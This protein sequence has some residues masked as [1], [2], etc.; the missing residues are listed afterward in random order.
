VAIAKDGTVEVQLDSNP[1]TGYTWTLASGGKG[2]EQTS[3][4]YT[5]N[6]ES[7]MVGGGGKQTYTF[8]ATGEGENDLVFVYK[9]AWEKEEANRAQV[10]VDI[11]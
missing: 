1:T 6:S 9:R 11:K 8:K 2:L 5:A 4:K 7:G 3:S 10:K